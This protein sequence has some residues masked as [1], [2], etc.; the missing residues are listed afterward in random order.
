[1]LNV[2][3]TVLQGEKC[4][5]ERNEQGRLTSSLCPRPQSLPGQHIR[6]RL[7]GGGNGIALLSTEWE[8]SCHFQ[9]LHQCLHQGW[10]LMAPRSKYSYLHQ[11]CLPLAH[12]PDQLQ[13][14]VPVCVLQ[15]S[16]SGLYLISTFL[17]RFPQCMFSHVLILSNNHLQPTYVTRI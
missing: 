10:N 8:H 7:L 2:F 6:Q 1:M 16:T 5:S 4:F 3:L 17:H 9:P 11:G 14:P 12:P 13:W 15:D